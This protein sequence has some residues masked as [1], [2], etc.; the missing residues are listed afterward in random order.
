[1]Q[2]F[3]VRFNPKVEEDRFFDI[4][5]YEPENIY[6]K[7]LGSLY[8]TG[9]LTNALPQNFKLIDS[10]TQIIRKKYYN[11]SFKS[12]EKALSE[13]LKKANEL[14]G[15]EVK[16]DNV[17]WMGNFNFSILSLKEYNLTFSAAGK[18]KILLMR[19]GEITDI[20]E[21]LNAQEIE[22]YPLK[23]FFNTVSGK[24]MDN[25][26]ILVASNDAYEFLEKKNIISKLAK[27][28]ELDKR[29]LKRFLSPSVIFDKKSKKIAGL[30]TLFV[31]DNKSSKTEKLYLFE[32]KEKVN[33]FKFLSTFSSNL[34]FIKRK[35]SKI[36]KNKPNTSITETTKMY[37]NGLN[38]IFS[39]IRKSIM[40]KNKKIETKTKISVKIQGEKHSKLP[41]I[42]LNKLIL[43]VSLFVV[44][45]LA[46]TITSFFIFRKKAEVKPIEIVVEEP[47]KE[48]II[49]P[50]NL[51]NVT[52]KFIF[53]YDKEKIE[54]DPQN[55]IFSKSGFYL[56]SPGSKKV[57]NFNIAEEENNKILEA[58]AE[59]ITASPFSNSAIFFSSPNNIYL[60]KGNKLDKSN[61]TLPKS[62]TLSL[63]SSYSSNLY[64]FDTNEKS[65]IKYPEK[66]KYVWNIS[67]PWS[68]NEL[69]ITPLALVA[70]DS[71]WILGTENKV[72]KYYK[73]EEK[74]TISV[75][76]E[77]KI[78]LTQIKTG[79]DIP[80]LY[81]LDSLNKRIIIASKEGKIVKQF[82]SDVFSGIK[83]IEISSDGKTIW[84][85][86]ESS[87]YEINFPF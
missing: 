40:K 6:E 35:A 67:K 10:V 72:V 47:K 21:S 58:S 78:E 85:L 71:L 22:P 14:L 29:G 1:M 66:S 31:I 57:Y 25:D 55:I 64:F 41:S 43:P 69:S 34:A 87:V 61:I 80:Y 51:E 75:N 4:F 45:A 17:D 2:I 13:S 37:V 16:K 3:D 62:S 39:S 26:K 63:F 86:C 20:G 11:F 83:S 24:L 60:P 50:E 36:I 70:E 48:V 28:K 59:I 27:A 79:L 53:S 46:T 56:W 38:F 7:R 23:V 68:K 74:E 30:F 15:E 52:P 49:N 65:I 33:F 8:V 76:L 12:Q 81:F 44:L 18:I 77:S 19:G 73:G 5:S 42:S 32:E 84:A 54:F 9:D 82:S